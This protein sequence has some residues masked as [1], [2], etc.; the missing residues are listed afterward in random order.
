MENFFYKDNF[1]R[2]F[3]SLIEYLEEDET[4]EELEDDWKIDIQLTDEEPIIQFDT[5][6]LLE[7][8]QE[9]RM[10]EE[11]NELGK[12]RKVLEKYKI[13]FDK[14]NAEVP[15]LHYVNSTKVQITKK[16]LLEYIS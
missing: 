15:K 4:I 6:M 8:V 16:D 14:I 2:D 7:L 11:G 9:D 1:Y 13:D 10:S 5:Q 3:D 12:L